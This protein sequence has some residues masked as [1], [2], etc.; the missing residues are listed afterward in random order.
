MDEWVVNLFKECMIVSLWLLRYGLEHRAV[1]DFA[2]AVL[3]THTGL[4]AHTLCI[5]MQCL[6]VFWRL[7][8]NLRHNFKPFSYQNFCQE[9]NEEC[10]MQHCIQAFL[11][12]I[13]CVCVCV[14]ACVCVCVCDTFFSFLLLFVHWWFM[15]WFCL[16]VFLVPSVSCWKSYWYWTGTVT[17]MPKLCW[18]T[19]ICSR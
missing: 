19:C 4:F 6:V 15:D 5:N 18:P 1:R 16:Y 9:T 17:W 13:V 14:H 2:D 7:H 10:S 12:Q 11:C 3:S 8:F